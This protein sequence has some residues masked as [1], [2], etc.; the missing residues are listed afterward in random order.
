[1]NKESFVIKT[2]GQQSGLIGD[3]AAV[4]GDT[5]YSQDAFFENVH[6]KKTWMNAYEIGYKAMIV[7]ISDAVAMN[8]KPRYALLTLAIPK[9][10]SK[11]NIE[12]LMRGLSDAASLYGCEIIGGD[13]IANVKLDISITIVSHSKKV[14][15]RKNVKEGDY[16]AF[17]GHLG[18]VKKDLIRLFRTQKCARSSRFIRPVLREKFVAKAYRAINSGMDI[19]DG[20]YEDSKKLTTTIRRSFSP[21]KKLPKSLVCSGEEYEML[22]SVPVRKVR[23]LKRIAKQTRTPLTIFAKVVRGKKIS[24]CKANHF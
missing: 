4:V 2:F 8:A 3:D 20:L 12:E 14:L 22:V 9:N 21:I 23:T 17:T 18:S 5:L 15:Q 11:K 16:L 10:E 24:Y 6:F 1:M 19:S 13:T 7:N